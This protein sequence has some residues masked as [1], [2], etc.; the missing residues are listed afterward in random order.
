MR[1]APT[2]PADWRASI[3]HPP[4]RAARRLLLEFRA[5]FMVSVVS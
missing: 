3:T 2:W 5:P 1:S 4:A